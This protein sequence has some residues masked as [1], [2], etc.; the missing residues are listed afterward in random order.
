MNKQKQIKTV[1]IRMSFE[2][3]TRYCITILK[4]TRNEEG[5]KLAEEELIRYAKELDKLSK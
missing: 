2:T 4:S 5:H 3:A 1:S